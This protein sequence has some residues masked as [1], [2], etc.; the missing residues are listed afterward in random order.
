VEFPFEPLSQRKLRA[1]ADRDRKPWM[2][3]FG[4]LRHLH[5]ETARIDR[6]IEEEFNQDEPE[7]RDLHL[8]LDGDCCNR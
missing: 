1:Q 3:T 8:V 7:D 2:K 5:K 6:I 4:K